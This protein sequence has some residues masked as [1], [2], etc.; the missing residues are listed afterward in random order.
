MLYNIG[1][2]KSQHIPTTIFH[3]RNRLK[4]ISKGMVV[5]PNKATSFAGN[6]KRC[7]FFQFISNFSSLAASR[8]YT[9]IY[10]SPSKVYSSIGFSRREQ[11]SSALLFFYCNNYTNLKQMKPLKCNCTKTAYTVSLTT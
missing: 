7:L 3:Y 11:P 5:T 1:V 8:F 2:F 10:T 4:I 9:S 6:V